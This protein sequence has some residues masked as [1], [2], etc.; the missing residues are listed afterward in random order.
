MKKKVF[1]LVLFMLVL[2]LATGVAFAAETEKKQV[3]DKSSTSKL[4]MSGS[5]EVIVSSDDE[6]DAQELDT[7]ADIRLNMD[8]DFNDNWQLATELKLAD[9]DSSLATFD[10]GDIE[11]IGTDRDLGSAVFGLGKTELTGKLSG[12]DF[13]AFYRSNGRDS[14]DQLGLFSAKDYAVVDKVRNERDWYSVNG[15]GPGDKDDYEGDQEIE[16]QT[17]GI[18]FSKTV[19]STEVYASILT[20]VNRDATEN[21]EA[22]DLN[23][24]QEESQ[25]FMLKAKRAL[26]DSTTMTAGLLGEAGDDKFE[27]DKMDLIDND[28]TAYVTADHN[29]SQGL[30]KGVNVAGELAG[31]EADG[32]AIGWA[33]KAG[34]SFGNVY[35][36]AF[37]KE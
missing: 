29:I 1:S 23:G 2:T 9:K 22:W 7:E 37:W 4:K 10:Y 20:K 11:R 32:D 35:V 16:N 31:S 15:W 21:T 6:D 5:V 14:G 36:E 28:A 24:I 12:G 19:G 34:K 17:A 3:E 26:G 25:L 30:F 27:S 18:D 8:Y 13:R 33:A